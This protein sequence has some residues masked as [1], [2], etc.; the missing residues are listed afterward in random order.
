[1]INSIIPTIPLYAPVYPLPLY[2]VTASETGSAS[3]DTATTGVAVTPSASD[4]VSDFVGI[5]VDITV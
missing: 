4:A 2:D 3:L 5:L 1:M